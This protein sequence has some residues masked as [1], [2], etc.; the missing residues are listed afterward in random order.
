MEQKRERH[1][2][3]LLAKVRRVIAIL[4]W[5]SITWLLLDF[6]G[7]AY[8]YLGWMAKM[9]FLPAVIATNLV[10]VGILLALTLVMGRIY[11]SV[12]CP[13]GV[14]QDIVAWVSK[15]RIFRKN[16]KARLA[17]KYSYSPTKRVARAVV[18]LLFLVLMVAG[19]NSLAIMIAPYSAY[20]RIASNIMQ[21]LYLWFNNGLA[22]I[23]EHYDSYAF[24]SV[25]VW[26]RSV[27][28]L[29]VAAIALVVIV[30]LAWRNGR[31]Y[32]NTIC[33]VGTILG[34]ASHFSIFGPVFDKEKCNG[35]RQCERNCKASCINVAD[36]HVDS[37]RCVMCGNCMEIC[38]QGAM[39][40]GKRSI[41]ADEPN[42]P[43]K[44]NG[45]P[46]DENRRN[47]LKGIAIV[48]TAT[49]LD[50]AAKTVDG[51]LAVIE[52]K[53]IP[54]RKTPLT[55]PGSLSAKHFAQHCT[56]CQLCI[57]ECP[58]QVLRPSDSWET[59]MQPTMQYERGYCRPECTR[60]SQLCPAGAIRP[61]STEEK[62]THQIGHAVWVKKN[63]LPV[64]DGVSCGNCARH[65]PVG[66]IEMVPLDEEADDLTMIPV[67][68]DS[69]C[70]G[71]GACENLC[72]ARPFS[73]IYVEGY[74]THR[75]V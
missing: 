46:V 39:R 22:S 38:Q 11:C 71:C 47:F 70:I 65:C 31:T 8:H 18:L 10:V 36:H 24:Y 37:T 45:Q 40:F 4:F 42:K 44:A 1:A 3:G 43:N 53:Q 51:G 27:S 61:L 75:E 29:A 41:G 69:L 56:A 55:P 12:V 59:L 30:V 54:K 9:Q 68:N 17:N 66:A 6:T 62:T 14:M 72:P 26:L 67:V 33:P 50:T 58:N 74:E 5:V 20:G 16:K 49:V 52:D 48:S 2:N 32:C 21:P 63:S 25:D 15:R 64:T 57:A 7:T 13:L 60:C 28:S 73:A 34:Y 35:C 19:M 23:A